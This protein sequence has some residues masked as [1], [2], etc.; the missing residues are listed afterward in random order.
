MRI[1][2]LHGWQSVPGGVKPTYLKDHGHEVINPK[3]PDDDF[4]ESIRIAQFEFDRHQPGVV[5]GSS[6][7]GAVAMNIDSG[8]A[9]LVLLCPAWKKFGAAKTVKPDTVILHSRADDVVPFADSEELVRNS[10]LPAEALIEVGGDHRLADPQSLTAMRTACDKTSRITGPAEPTRPSDRIL[11]LDVLRGFALLGI[12]PINIL[13][14]ALPGMLA[15]WNPQL[16]IEPAIGDRA[17]WLFQF[18]F[19]AGKMNPMLA[20]LFG[21]G[22]VLLA[23][24]SIRRRTRPIGL[25]YRR[26]AILLGIGLIHAYLLWPAT[27][28]V[29]L[30][31]CGMLCYPLRSLPAIAIIAAGVCA[32]LLSM[33]LNATRA[34]SYVP[35]LNAAYRASEAFINAESVSDADRQ[36]VDAWRQMREELYP[37][38]F[39]LNDETEHIRSIGYVELF[40]ER[41]PKTYQTQIALPYEA[42]FW[43]VAAY[44]LF[45]MG[46]TRLGTFVRPWSTRSCLLAVVIGYGA[47][48]PILVDAAVRLVLTRF[49]I[50]FLIVGG[51]DLSQVGSGLVVLGH[52]GS[53]MLLAQT[54]SD[55]PIALRLA[56]VG[57]TALSNYF[58]QSIMCT[59]LFCGYGFGLFGQFNR[60]QLLAIVAAIWAFEIWISWRWL[61]AF[62]FGPMEWIWRSLTYGKMQPLR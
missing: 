48:L 16:A 23:D 6:R 15:P 51:N 35:Y 20:I 31:L 22:L 3:L 54:G 38:S 49:D 39:R 34:A 53:L 26:L 36:L 1:L 17:I 41:A 7:G 19:V 33:H 44:M 21:A 59:A 8:N 46:M 56:E 32:M 58:L 12:L 28:L 60:T 42:G 29:V 45:G 47:G 27:I 57:R 11:L 50:E 25:V 13:H 24:H 37:D 62:R 52:V 40:A 9:R 10:G 5:V 18:L 55:L 30:P 43:S 4:D 2:F 61:Q 14:L